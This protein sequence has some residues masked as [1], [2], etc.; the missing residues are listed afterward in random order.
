MEQKNRLP[1]IILLALCGCL[2]LCCVIV[3]AANIGG[4]RGEK[5]T[6]TTQHTTEPYSGQRPAGEWPSEFGQRPTGDFGERPTGTFGGMPPGDMPDTKLMRD[7][8]QILEAANFE[9]TDDVRA[10]LLALGMTQ[11]QIEMLVGMPNRGPRGGER[12]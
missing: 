7:A 12:P 6:Q 9:L 5:E 2:V 8:M 10:S 1:V 3:Y 11:Q 4:V